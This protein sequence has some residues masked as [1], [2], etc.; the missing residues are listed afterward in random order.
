MIPLQVEPAG[1]AGP[2]AFEVK[3]PDGAADACGE[4]AE[5]GGGLRLDQPA[6][7]SGPRLG[8]G[9]LAQKQP[10]DPAVAGPERQPPAGSEVEGVGMA[11]QLG[12]HGG[13]AGAA[14]PLLEHPQNLLLA[15]G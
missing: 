12:E 2:V 7:G 1:H 10:H 4:T 13:K 11:A 8:P 3:P 9:G 6:G 5:G 15:G 14:K